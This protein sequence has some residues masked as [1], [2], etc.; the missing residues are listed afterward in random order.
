MIIKKLCLLTVALLPLLAQSSAQQNYKDPVP[1]AAD[2]AAQAQTQDAIPALP[3]SEPDPAPVTEEYRITRKV[4]HQLV[5]QPSYSIWDWL[6]FRVNG[7]TVELLGDVYSGGLKRNAIDA[8]KQ[9]DGVEK[10]IDHIKLLSSSPSDE[11][12]RHQVA[13][14]IYGSGSLASY[15][16]SAM[17]S[18]H[19][20]V[21][22]G[23]VRLEG[24]VDNQPDKDAAAL[25]ANGVAGVLQVTNNLRIEKP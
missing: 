22:G 18:I 8:V 11:Q 6:A 19:I 1:V 17:P 9:I 2:A 21:N 10:V 24:V 13:D 7:S 14:A 3:A 23:Q 25:R 15:S 16:W 20:I 4:R 5:M 12:I